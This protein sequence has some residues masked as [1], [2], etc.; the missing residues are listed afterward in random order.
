MK[1]KTKLSLLSFAIIAPLAACNKTNNL[2]PIERKS[3]CVAPVNLT[4]DQ[5]D[6][7]VSHQNSFIAI[8]RDDC[9][10]AYNFIDNILT[11]II[12]ENNS[13]IYLLIE[14][15]Y[16]KSTSLNDIKISHPEL[17]FF[18]NGNLVNHVSAYNKWQDRPSNITK[19]KKYMQKYAYFET[20]MITTTL[21]EIKKLKNNNETFFVYYKWNLCGDCNYFSVKFLNKWQCN[22]KNK[23][24]KIY[25][26]EVGD[27]GRSNKESEEWQQFVNDMQLS[28]SSNSTYG[29]LDGK[30]P[31]LQ[32]YKDGT[33]SGCAVIYNAV[34]DKETNTVTN[35]YY[36]NFI[37]NTYDGY[38]D[39]QEKTLSFYKDK[40]EE[41]LKELY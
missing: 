11:P 27:Y 2:I 8:T 35:E 29:Y 28:S 20:P 16:K 39:Y 30:V 36:H 25:V 4:A 1:T 37:G 12:K 6:L 9:T 24:K 40:F 5:F 13:V 19:V 23:D 26:I 10:C 41:L 31:A 21:T 15:E 22:T 7:M 3:G 32:Y 18:L 14:D 33:L 34:L 38:A 17:L